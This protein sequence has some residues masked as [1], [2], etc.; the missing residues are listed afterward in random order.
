MSL[1]PPVNGPVQWAAGEGKKCREYD[2]QQSSFNHEARSKQKQQDH[3]RQGSKHVND[4]CPMEGPG[5]TVGWRGEHGRD[6]EYP[7]PVLD[8]GLYFRALFFHKECR[9]SQKSAV[10]ARKARDSTPRPPAAIQSSGSSAEVIFFLGSSRGIPGC[11]VALP[12]CSNRVPQ[13]RA[14]NEPEKSADLVPG[15]R[16][17]PPRA[18]PRL[19]GYSCP[20]TAIR[21]A[22]E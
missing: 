21:G 17:P 11:R 16:P 10:A 1:S 22:A 12:L 18:T 4:H 19:P 14:Y 20:G 7:A 15:K 3:V 5:Q 8:Q 6:S 2:Y 13:H 9:S